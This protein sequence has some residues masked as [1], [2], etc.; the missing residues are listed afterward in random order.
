MEAAVSPTPDATP[1]G[2]APASAAP[3]ARRKPLW[4]A[5]LRFRL[6]ASYTLLVAIVL[7][8]LSVVVYTAVRQTMTSQTERFL[9]T[10]AHRVAQEAQGKTP[11]EMQ[12]RLQATI[13]TV[14]SAL[15]SGPIREAN[16]PIDLRHNLGVL[17]FSR[18]S[19][20]VVS[21]PG[22]RIIAQS[23]T[24]PKR[25]HML[26][27]V[28]DALGHIQPVSPYQFH[29]VPVAGFQDV[30]TVAKRMETPHGAVYIQV[31][32]PWGRDADLLA[33]LRWLLE[34]CIVM[35]CLLAFFGG[36]LL[37]AHSLRPV[38]RVVEQVRRATERGLE[39]A[40]LPATEDAD[41]EIG[42]L[43]GTFNELVLR[44]SRSLDAQRRFSQD[45]AHELQTPAS[46]LRL[47][48]E[49]ALRRDR[50]AS[51][52]RAAIESAI[53]DVARI[54]RIV[55]ALSFT[56]RSCDWEAAAKFAPV[57]L[58]ALART[59]A[60][61]FRPL[62]TAR[63]ITLSV[64]AAQAA[65]V[66]GDSG[67]LSEL[68]GNLIDNAIKYTEPG[69][70]V[71]VTVTPQTGGKIAAAVSDTGCGLEP[72]ELPHVFERFWRSERVRTVKGSGLGLAIC[73]R[74]ARSHNGTI[75]VMRRPE[76]GST[77][78]IELPGELGKPHP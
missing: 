29:L 14:G 56:A 48:L 51:E 63:N 70:K 54:S 37:V 74:I 23:G 47:Q 35:S 77:F 78:T 58:A 13:A 57:D 38:Y 19:I 18:T 62:A 66:M 22:H 45:A 55:D 68:L 20:R 39:S 49:S 31:A 50:P 24:L 4:A 41:E 10:I 11:E 42:Q 46:I 21:D 28:D 43:I 52:L 32:M 25:P 67:Q 64:E 8:V 12:A 72:E 40:A 16:L 15:D 27:G 17:D 26:L 71:A 61:A 36:R 1:F 59:T 65:N 53:E 76:G 44:L 6:A 34:A 60:D 33:R 30:Y 73:E 3:S 5:S 69:G 2:I 7:S 9:A 75:H